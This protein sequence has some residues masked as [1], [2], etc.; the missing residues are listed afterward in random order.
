MRIRTARAL[1]GAVF[2]VTV[3]AF[4]QTPD[5]SDHPSDANTQRS[6]EDLNMVGTDTHMPPIQESILGDDSEFRRDWFRQGALLRMNV[7][8]SYTQNTLDAP[9]TA[10]RQAY[11]GE[12]PFESLM[13]N[14]IFTA[15][16]RQLHL[17]DAQ[18]NISG[19]FFWVSW[20]RAGP[21]AIT[22]QSLYLY[23]SFAEKRIETKAGYLTNSWEFMGRE[24]GGSTA[25]GALG[26]YA[27]LPYEVGLSHSPLISPAFNLRIAGPSH[28][29]F[30]SGVQR[31]MDPAGGQAAIAR[32][33]AGFRFLAKGDKMLLIDEIG[34]RRDAAPD[35]RETWLRAGSLYNTTPYPNSRTGGKDPGNYCAYLLA[36]RQLTGDSPEHPAKGLYGGATAMVVPRELNVY[37]KYFEFRLYQKGTFRSRPADMASLVSSRSDYSTDSIRNLLA[38][39][40]TVWHNSNSVTG[41]Y[42]IHV[43]RGNFVSLGLSYVTGP[44]IAPRVNNALTFGV[45]STIFF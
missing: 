41:S 33:E 18:L 31:A 43:S 37:T 45:V 23:K 26:V 42:S 21:S 1:L 9:V 4:A 30:K 12:R 36:D 15:D 20:E 3:S 22:L 2:L 34:Y 13:A 10:S 27:V 32:N 11:V 38:A 6:I 17:R 24:V 14:P 5:S 29:Y 8:G 28:T 44:A 7:S 25:A 40:N 39:G 35:K 16:L 19:G